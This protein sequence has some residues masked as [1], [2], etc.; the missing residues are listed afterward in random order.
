MLK[1]A[2]DKQNETFERLKVLFGKEQSIR[3]TLVGATAC[4]EHG[5][6]RLTNDLDIVVSPYATAMAAILNSGFQE[7][8]DDLDRTGRTCTQVDVIT[9]VPVDFLTGG[10]LINDGSFQLRGGI[11]I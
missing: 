3:F 7:C 4:R 5:L 2:T 8:R 9:S 1:R 10:I 6:T 11:V